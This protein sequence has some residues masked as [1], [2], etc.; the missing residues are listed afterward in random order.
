MCRDIKKRN[1]ITAEAVVRT[2][3]LLVE[4]FA[5]DDKAIAEFA[6]KHSLSPADL[7]AYRNVGRGDY[8]IRLLEFDTP[9]RVAARRL[10]RQHGI[11]LLEQGVD[12]VTQS[13]EELNIPL[14]KLT[15]AQASQAVGKTV[16]QQKAKLAR[17]NIVQPF[18]VDGIRF[19][20]G[21]RCV[22]TAEQLEPHMNQLMTNLYKHRAKVSAA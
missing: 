19:M 5:S 7:L 13:G 10:N 18:R 14:D 1:A 22:V 2:G 15:K 20:Q 12:V 16:S 11:R 6:D 21:S 4:M 3:R 8:D 9:G 17:R